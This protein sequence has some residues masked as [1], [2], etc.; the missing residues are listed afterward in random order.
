MTFTWMEILLIMIA[1]NLQVFF[2]NSTQ[3]PGLQTAA[4]TN[5]GSVSS[6]Q[7]IHS[8]VFV[9]ILVSCIYI[10]I[11]PVFPLSRIQ[12]TL[13]TIKAEILYVLT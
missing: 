8:T 2:P 5:S 10:G 12:R 7:Y 1:M 3:F 13:V 6:I 4:R 11:T 9:V